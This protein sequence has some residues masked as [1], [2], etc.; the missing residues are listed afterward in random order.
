MNT[1]KL[2]FLELNQEIDLNKEVKFS[3]IISSSSNVCII[4]NSTGLK[5]FDV[6]YVY[7]IDNVISDNV[8]TF[9]NYGHYVRI[10]IF[11]REEFAFRNPYKVSPLTTSE[12]L[13]LRGGEDVRFQAF[14]GM[15]LRGINCLVE[16]IAL[17][18]KYGLDIDALPGHIRDALLSPTPKSLT[19][20]IA[21]SPRIT[22]I[23]DYLQKSPMKGALRQRYFAA[24][25]EE[26]LCE[27]V[28]SLNISYSNK[29][30]LILK[31]RNDYIKKIIEEAAFIYRT[32]IGELPTVEQLSL[33]LG[34]NK[35]ILTQGFF[36]AYG[37]GPGEY[38]RMKSLEWAK[39]Q[40][41][42]GLFD[43]KQISASAGYKNPSAFT[44]AY[45]KYFGITPSLHFENRRAK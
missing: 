2:N 24:K 11:L 20:K 33:R 17:I 15:R 39:N 43:V 29:S 36:D 14:A 35:N 8:I 30:G 34:I 44:R 28:F 18:D 12:A 13:I 9:A 26:I 22:S 7:F 19:W 6:G 38:G 32:E 45:S 37:M 16:P 1:F 3:E 41:E 25:I 31:S 4:E 23:I 21:L 10:S 40:I 27:I 5:L 42:T